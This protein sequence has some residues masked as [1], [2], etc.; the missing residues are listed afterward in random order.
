MGSV[1]PPFV[2]LDRVR[3]SYKGHSALQDIVIALDEVH[4]SAV[5]SLLVF[6]FVKSQLEL[7]RMWRERPVGTGTDGAPAG[8]VWLSD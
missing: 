2:I 8:G 7:V 1:W 4:S 3:T 6:V 5:L